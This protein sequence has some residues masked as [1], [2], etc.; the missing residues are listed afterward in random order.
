[1]RSPVRLRSRLG[2]R[3][4]TNLLSP[5]IMSPSTKFWT[6][7]GPNLD[8]CWK[9]V[10]GEIQQ[11]SKKWISGGS[12]MP[13]HS[14]EKVRILILYFRGLR[15][16]WSW[17][18]TPNITSH[19]FDL[20]LWHVEKWA[21]RVG[22]TVDVASFGKMHAWQELFFRSTFLG[23]DVVTQNFVFMKL[24]ADSCRHACKS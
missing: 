10:L 2:L 18:S 21:S 11:F 19:V 20:I 12:F 8:F 7:F 5:P 22:E 4:K 16:R 14:H 13:N 15:K 17:R 24:W 1:M 23:N 9:A 6:H 3:G